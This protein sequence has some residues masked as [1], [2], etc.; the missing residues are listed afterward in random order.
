MFFELI[1]FMFPLFYHLKFV[2]QADESSMGRWV[3][4]DP[5]L[6]MQYTRLLARIWVN[7]R[8]VLRIPLVICILST[9]LNIY[10]LPATNFECSTEMYHIYDWWKKS[11]PPNVR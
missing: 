9:F 4:R 8:G 3:G 2:G 6:R 10:N 11:L 5:L 7:I 1:L